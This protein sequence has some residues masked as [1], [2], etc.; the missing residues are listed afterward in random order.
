MTIQQVYNQLR[1]PF[2]YQWCGVLFSQADQLAYPTALACYRLASMI[3]DSGF[4]DIDVWVN[5]RLSLGVSFRHYYPSRW[6]AYK[7]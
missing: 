1:K 4:T 5:A 6:L 3:V 7:D 2:T